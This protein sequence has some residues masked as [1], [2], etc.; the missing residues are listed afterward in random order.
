M[1]AWVGAVALV[2]TLAS[3]GAMADGNKLLEFCQSTVRYV[4]TKGVEGDT[5]STGYCLGV[6]TGVTS[7]RGLTNPGLP[8]NAQTCPPSP[9]PSATQVARISV[10]YM[11]ENPERLNLDDGVLILLA[12]QRAYPCK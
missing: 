7:L 8:K 10:K 6:I 9:P 12:L 4:D 5:F 3:G 2:G 11:T 1:K